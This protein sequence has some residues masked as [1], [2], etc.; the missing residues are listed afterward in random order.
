MAEA[1]HPDVVVLDIGLPDISGHEVARR[2]RA[3]K[4]GEH[5][6]LIALTALEDEDVRRRSTEVGC[7][8]HL[9][10]PVR[11]QALMHVLGK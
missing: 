1:F 11:L 3:G 4:G 7:E 10:K 6:R 9:V 5:I 2:L 8:H